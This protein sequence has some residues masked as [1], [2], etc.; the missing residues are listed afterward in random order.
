MSASDFG[1]N[2]TT[3][4]YDF[5]ANVFTMEQT[6]KRVANCDHSRT[7]LPNLVKYGPQMEK[8]GPFFNPLNIN[9]LARSYLRL[10]V[11]A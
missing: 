6:G 8:M 5:I 2:V 3:P 9:F 1:K 4:L 7:C 11:A 10:S